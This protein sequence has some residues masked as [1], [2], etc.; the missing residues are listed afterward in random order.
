MKTVLNTFLALLS[1]IVLA[2]C[3]S[4]EENQQGQQ[5]QSIEQTD[6]V[7]SNASPAEFKAMVDQHTGILLDVRTP[8]EIAESHIAGYI[9]ID[10]NS[11][12]FENKLSELDKNSTYLVYCRSGNRSMKAAKKMEKMGFKKVV[13]LDAGIVGWI[14]AGYSVE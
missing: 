7:I 5:G 4:G 6:Q 12:D 2:Q 11:A 14:N 10:F 13:N 1:C 9:A 3:Q 8:G